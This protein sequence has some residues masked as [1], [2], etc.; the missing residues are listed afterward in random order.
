M[1]IIMKWKPWS[2]ATSYFVILWLYLIKVHVD[3][4]RRSE[5]N[6]VY[7]INCIYKVKASKCTLAY[8]I[9]KYLC[10][11]YHP[12]KGNWLAIA[13]LEQR[14]SKRRQKRNNAKGRPWKLLS[15]CLRLDKAFFKASLGWSCHEHRTGTAWICPKKSA[16]KLEWLTEFNIVKRPR[17]YKMR[18]NV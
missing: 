9:L 7:Q 18:I 1:H 15:K 3:I 11:E 13:F 17:Q 6:S 16:E 4:G 5:G 14:H 10:L 12:Q 2:S 8:N